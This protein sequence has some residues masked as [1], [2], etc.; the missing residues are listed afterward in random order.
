MVLGAIGAVASGN[1]ASG[2]PTASL[3]STANNSWVLGVGNDYDNATART[4][5][6]GQS[7]IHQ[8]LTST[9]D[10][11][12]VQMLSTPVAVAGSTVMVN[13]TAPTKD[14]YNLGIV[15]ILPATTGTSG[16]NLSGTIS[17][18]AAGTGSMVTLS[19]AA[20][21]TTTADA[22]G[23]YSFSGVANGSYTI[24]PSKS[25]YTFTPA[26]QNVAVNGANQTGLNFTAQST[27]TW[28][29]SGTLTPAA[30]GS[31]AT[32]TLGGAAAA[33]TIADANGNYTFTGLPN[34]SYTITPGK[35][36]YTFSPAS[37]PV[38]I[39]GAN[40]SGINFTVQGTGS[41]WSISGV[42]SPSAGGGGGATV[43]LNGTATA[44]TTADAN[45]NYSF[46]SLATGSYTVTPSKSGY[47]F[48]P[49]SQ[50]V[51]INAADVSGINFTAVAPANAI[52]LDA[53][54]STDGARA[55]ATIAS[56]VLLHLC[57]Q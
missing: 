18:V 9:G 49:A 1:A 41:S 19:G 12:W 54:V 3:V 43:A 5:G 29:I 10:T 57:C 28:S 50:P 46:A 22:H 40:Q 55:S 30:A 2:A 39:N 17:P 42:L 51:T 44:T 45:G 37:Q 48:S 27:A 35:S 36:G 52:S 6:A 20:N 13:D 23:N 31:G 53:K 21:A 47:T 56:P 26:N 15:E 25:G 24:T 14:R 34:G 38:T 33:T 4:V 32:V 11:Y 8:Y 7:L 16:W